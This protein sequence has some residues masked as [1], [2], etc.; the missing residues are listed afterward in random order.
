MS[1][2]HYDFLAWKYYGETRCEISGSLHLQMRDVMQGW[3][4]ESFSKSGEMEAFER[5]PHAKILEF[6]R[7]TPKHRWLAGSALP[8]N[9]AVALFWIRTTVV[10]DGQP[11]SVC[12]VARVVLTRRP[13][14]QRQYATRIP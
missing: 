13:V 8:V 6:S 1:N 5:E 3:D 4:R 2:L 11:L 7:N 14:L 12:W 10:G 9:I